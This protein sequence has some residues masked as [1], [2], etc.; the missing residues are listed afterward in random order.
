MRQIKAVGFDFTGVIGGIH[1]SFAE[2][3]EKLCRILDV[4]QDE[5]HTVYFSINKL[6]NTGQVKSWHEF[7]PILLEK[8]GRKAKLREYLK[9]VDSMAEQ[10]KYVN[11]QMIDLVDHL[12]RRGYK[13]GLLSNATAQ[14][15]QILRE[16]GV[17]SHFDTFIIS[18]EVGLQKPDPELFRLFS[19][20]LGVVLEELVFIDDA[21]TSLKTAADCGFTPILF[22]GYDQLTRDLKSLQIPLDH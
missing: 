17:D 1:A 13:T 9:A 3:V 14:T 19:S 12:R 2:Y 4:T 22:R 7:A 5:Y 20:Q 18:A 11:P 6:I 21:E 15:G 8:L 16:A 10:Q